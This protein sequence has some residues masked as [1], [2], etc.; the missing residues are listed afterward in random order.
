MA[1]AETTATRRPKRPPRATAEGPPPRNQ[2]PTA[3]VSAADADVN[4]YMAAYIMG[5]ANRLANAAS[6]YYRSR[7]DIGMSEWRAMMAIGTSTDRIGREVAEMADLDYAAASK[8]LKILEARGFV[9]MTPTQ[10]RG[11][12][13]IVSLTPDGLAVWRELRD[14]ARRRQQR[15]LAAFSADEVETLWSLLRRV[16][17]QVPQMN[18]GR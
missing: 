3:P 10:R 15:L 12:A 11:R 18:A 6:Q 14:S 13:A 2:H 8:S 17:A 4:R 9:A 7:F 5:V 16:E 1:E